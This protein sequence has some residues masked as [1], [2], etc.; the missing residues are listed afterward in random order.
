MGLK[1]SSKRFVLSDHTKNLLGFVTI[2][3]GIDL[4]AFQDNPVM[5]YDHDYGL[6]I[7]QW[8]DYRIEGTN[9]T[10]APAFDEEDEFAMKQ[11]NKVEA[12][13]LRGASVGLSPVKFNQAKSELS[14]C[15]LLEASLTPV[16]NNKKALAIYNDTGKKLNASEVTQYLL[17][18]ERTDYTINNNENMDKNLITAL[19][20]L[21]VQ[22]GHTI[23][24]T[25]DSKP[26]D[27]E[28]A[29]K[30]VGEK[31]TALAVEKITLAARVSTL[32][33][34]QKNIATKKVTDLV[35]QAVTDKLLS[36]D[37][38]PVFVE[39]GTLSLSALE[40]ALKA[41]KPVSLIVV[42]GDKTKAAPVGREAWGFDD[43][44][45]NAPADL[46]LMQHA[47]PERFALL[48]SAKTSTARQ[49]FSIEA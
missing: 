23:N 43:Y 45:L 33:A 36:A 5:L 48:L 20:A 42:P 25:A 9:L 31:M 40:T 6:L 37:Q 1:V 34:E 32:E 3:A 11:Y 17:S 14:A 15:I 28:N 49:K 39:L 19:A 27:F 30:K 47:E 10:A 41:M 22:A 2:T 12:G 21:C 16:P 35:D 24:L 44:A 26:E 4:S 13:I 46:E 29:V 18:V 38:K 7:G 8:V